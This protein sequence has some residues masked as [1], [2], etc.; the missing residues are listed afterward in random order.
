L[1]RQFVVGVDSGLLGS[2]VSGL[3]QCRVAAL[4]VSD[5]LE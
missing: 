5:L 3:S 1:V 2:E 4:W